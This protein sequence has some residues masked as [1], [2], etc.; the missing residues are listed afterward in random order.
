MKKSYKK[1]IELAVAI[2]CVLTVF[3]TVFFDVSLN[4]EEQ[5]ENIEQAQVTNEN[6]NNDEAG[7]VGDVS[8]IE[9]AKVVDESESVAVINEASFIE[10][11]ELVDQQ[12]FT[13]VDAPQ[14]N[15]QAP[16]A[17][18]ANGV[19]GT[20]SWTLDNSGVLTFS[21][22]RLPDSWIDFTWRAYGSGTTKYVFTAPITAGKSLANFAITNK[23]VEIENLNFIDT[24]LTTDMRSMFSGAT[25]LVKVDVSNF[26]TS[27]VLDMSS[28]FRDCQSLESIDVSNWDT[29]KVTTMNEMFRKTSKLAAE[30]L[31][32]EANNWDTSSVLT[33]NSM[34]LDA[35]LD[36]LDIRDWNV[37]K[38]KDM[39]FLFKGANLTELNVSNWKPSSVTSMLHTFA[40]NPNLVT[41]DV[42]EWDVSSVVEM[43]GMFLNCN[44]LETIDV[45]RWDTSSVTSM[46]SVFYNC[47]NLTALDVSNWNTSA[48]TSFNHMF[49]ECRKLDKLDL[50]GWD[51]S[52]AMQASIFKTA[53]IKEITMNPN[54]RFK[55]GVQN[56][57]NLNTPPTDNTYSGKWKYVETGE[58]I[59]QDELL[60]YDGSNPGT[61]VWAKV[62]FNV[63]FNLNDVNGTAPPNQQV[64]IGSL[65]TKPADPFLEGYTFIKWTTDPMGRNEWDFNV[66]MMPAENVVLFAQ[67]DVPYQ[68]DFYY[69]QLD[70]TYGLTETVDL[71]GRIVTSVAAPEQSTLGFT[72]DRLHPNSRVEGIVTPDGT[73]KLEVYYSRNSY[74]VTFKDYDGSIIESSSL[75]YEAPLIAPA[76][77]TRA[78][79]EFSHWSEVTRAIQPRQILATVPNR[80][81][82]YQANY[83]STQTTVAPLPPTQPVVGRTCQ[84][85]GYPSGYY[86]NGSACVLPQ[87]YVVPK[88]GVR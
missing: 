88:T 41:L 60:S 83:I 42:S 17:L 69:E 26:N 9:A 77:P 44:R 87:S 2:A 56:I 84:D 21:G 58:M 70:G 74:T 15:V 80:D 8:T 31:K 25:S 6:G 81:V 85:D 67:W 71:Q 45:S 50:S 36:K 5:G 82:V 28:M 49:I 34:F 76:N 62:M 20:V 54:Y 23:I 13:E 40:D 73:L 3:G 61:Y 37:T 33:M 29:S 53:T 32:L 52:N 10:D 46:S 51:I 66:D 16:R 78:S 38:V 59:T 65:P 4:A 24:S 86:W 22:G 18:I 68:V 19:S 72:L 75:K 39:M 7:T 35:N 1:I 79:F 63:S 43:G 55:S 11:G 30:P 14:Q 57:E 12:I 27:N 64:E 48:V 47:Y